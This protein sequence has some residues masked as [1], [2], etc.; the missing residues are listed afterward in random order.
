MHRR[1]F[2]LTGVGIPFHPTPSKK[3]W[4]CH[5]S[6][7]DMFSNHPQFIEMK[8]C[9]KDRKLKINQ[10]QLPLKRSIY[11]VE[12]SVPNFT[13][14]HLSRDYR[15]EPFYQ[16]IL[17]YNYRHVLFMSFRNQTNTILTFILFFLLQPTVK[18]KFIFY[19][20]G[21]VNY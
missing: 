10:P 1:G 11:V 19:K 3:S 8:C 15:Y 9:H 13:K 21:H 2:Q 14:F 18:N 4:I 12:L 20:L 6:L 5:G 17:F 16:F 7:R